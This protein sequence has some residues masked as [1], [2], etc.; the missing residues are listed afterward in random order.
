VSI[1]EYW[2]A[3]QP[4]NSYDEGGEQIFLPCRLVMTVLCTLICLILAILIALLIM[5]RLQSSIG[6]TIDSY[7]P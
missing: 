5:A 3:P 2:L 7:M 6:T 1:R 4:T